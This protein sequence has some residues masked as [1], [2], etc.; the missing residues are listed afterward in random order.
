MSESESALAGKL[1][2]VCVLV[3]TTGRASLAR[4]VQSALAQEGTEVSVKIV[5]ARELPLE[6]VAHLCAD[7]RVQ[8]IPTDVPLGRSQAANRALASIDAPLALFLDDD[9]WLLPG[10]LGRLAT[11]LRERPDAVAAHAGVEC[12]R[13]GD[14]GGDD[15]ASL[16]VFDEPVDPVEM[17]LR[18]Q[19]PIHAVLF[20][21]AA[22]SGPPA[23][24]FDESLTHFEDWDFW[25]QLL[26]RGTMVHVPGVSAVY[27][28][29]DS[30][31]S[32]HAGE[33]RDQRQAWLRAFAAG[34]L[35]RWTP[36]L[37]AGMIDRNAA[38]VAE[39][40]QA[41]QALAN[42]RRE[43]TEQWRLVDED[44]SRWQGL[45]RTA[46][47]DRDALQ[48]QLASERAAHRAQ[49]DSELAAHRTVVDELQRLLA[50]YRVEGDKL[51]SLR[52]EHLAQIEQLNGQVQALLNS[53]SW[54]ITRP[55]RLFVGLLRRL[56][57]GAWS[58]PLRNLGVALQTEL[59]RFGWAGLLRRMPNHLRQWRVRW[60]VL[61]APVPAQQPEWASA[62]RPAS[63]GPML[64]AEIDGP[65]PELEHKVSV[66][67]PTLNGGAE[68]DLLLRKLRDQQGVAEVEIVVVDSGSSD[69]TV[70]HARA[71]G[72]VVVQIT[73]AEFSHSHARNLGADA[74]SGDFVLFMV[75][76]AFP[77]GRYWLHSMLAWLLAHRTQ[78]VVA[79]S[80]SEYCRSDSDLMY[81]SMVH[82][83]YRFLGCHEFDRIGELRGTDHMALRSLGQLSDVAC[84]IDRSTFQAYR[85]RG[86]YAEDLDLGIRLIRDG[87]KVAMLASVKVI[88]SHNR[89]ANY[90]LKRSF[91][92]VIFLV[93]MFDDFL[94]PPCGSAAGLI[95]GVLA[96]ARRLEAWL[97]GLA[98]P[99]VAFDWDQLKPTR[100]AWRA[101]EVTPH[102]SSAPASACIDESPLGDARL[103]RFL[104]ELPG[105]GLVMGQGESRAQRNDEARKFHD[106]FVA[107]LDHVLQFIESVY[108][109]PDERLREEGRQA[110]VKIFASAVGAALAFAYLGRHH[111]PE[112]APE[113]GWIENLYTSLKAGV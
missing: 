61:V 23:M 110:V 105:S 72:A 40:R 17:Q 56:R 2:E 67:I 6:V 58:M 45:A 59:R 9:D 100:W 28:L 30:S 84:L 32:G 38:M 46:D 104:V 99:S 60:R 70:A 64:H 31:G 69:D 109:T 20:R 34:Q 98:E 103:A 48:A 1:P 68:F 57:Q 50:A 78:G 5:A 66:V 106:S 27:L 15:E 8:V 47:R 37:V 74:A 3:R 43:F 101:S 53:T 91:V 52:L 10:H 96:T 4:A 18:N 51:A 54:R 11:A 26:R 89:T 111:W 39:V 19:L 85:Y 83:H 76:D 62:E 65:G 21:S 42:G 44:R 77:I 81:D 75:Q 80:C 55:L 73:P 12:R 90:Y 87:H 79:A 82:T 86:D 113:R 63:L 88:H 97:R 95:D 94:S 29:S 92:D 14:D 13:D 24:G 112:S 108:G 36:G 35:R 102:E 41:G 107:R 71:H 16:M 49:I 22:V 93:G 7:P 25:L 33:D